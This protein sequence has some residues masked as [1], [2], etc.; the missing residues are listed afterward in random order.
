[1]NIVGIG[2]DLLE[3]ARLASIGRKYGDKFYRRLF[4]DA[5]IAYCK[6]RTHPYQ[7]YAARFA[8]KEAVFKALGVGWAQGVR[9]MDV[10]VIRQEKGPPTVRISGVAKELADSLGV[11]RTHL[12]LSHTRELAMANVVLEGTLSE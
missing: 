2:S 7:H 4:T 3:V 5:E 8:A 1:M 11:S 9:W 10:E 12:T 6:S